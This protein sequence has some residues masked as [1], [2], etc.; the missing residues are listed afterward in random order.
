MRSR[1]KG[2]LECRITNI[3]GAKDKEFACVSREGLTGA[4]AATVPIIGDRVLLT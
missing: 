1:K 4:D 3:K 2:G